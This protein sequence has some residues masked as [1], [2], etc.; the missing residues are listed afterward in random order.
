MAI[1]EQQTIV[2]TYSYLSTVAL[3]ISPD[4][5]IEVAGNSQSLC[6]YERQPHL[7]WYISTPYLPTQV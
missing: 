7:M 5:E 4:E 1:E 3:Y 6:E 2:P